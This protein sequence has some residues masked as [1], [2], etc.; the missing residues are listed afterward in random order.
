MA[1]RKYLG[2]MILGGFLLIS[3]V[4]AF[5][6][7]YPSLTQIK[8]H[9]RSS[10]LTGLLTFSLIYLAA[11]LLFVPKNIL[12]L[13]AGSVFGFFLGALVVLTGAIAGA[14]VAFFVSRALG[15]ASMERLLRNKALKIERY[16]SNHQ[17]RTLLIGRLIPVIPFTLLN[18][19]AGLSPIQLWQYFCATLLGILP[20]TL[21]FLLI[22]AYGI[23]P[24]SWQFITG[25]LLL[26]LLFLANR[27]MRERQ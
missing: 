7:K 21:S 6:Y 23:H 5:G 24:G 11:S 25:A 18:Y 27:L 13:V 20:G 10:G 26:L 17:F 12:T 19:A 16:L 8:S 22:G 1:V 14:L 3:A 15:R 2:L 4:V 9:F